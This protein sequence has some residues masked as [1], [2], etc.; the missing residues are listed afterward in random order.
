MTTP[1][2]PAPGISEAEAKH[3]ASEMRRSAQAIRD[4][5]AGRGDER[6]YLEVAARGNDRIAE[7]LE[8]LLAERREAVRALEFVGLAARQA[9]HILTLD[10][11]DLDAMYGRKFTT[12]EA[13]A[14]LRAV[15]QR[16]ESARSLLAPAPERKE[17]E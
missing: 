15:I 17:T 5:I 7:I 16:W 8:A 4:E 9:Y 10:N 11:D 6:P 12:D 14:G 1:S 3:A 13:F 2:A